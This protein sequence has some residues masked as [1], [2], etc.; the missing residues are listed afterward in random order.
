MTGTI[1]RV[2]FFI[3]LSA[4]AASAWA[5]TV[6]VSYD[7]VLDAPEDLIS[8]DYVLETSID[9]ESGIMDVLF[10]QGHIVFN[11]P[12]LVITD[13]EAAPGGLEQEGN[14]A[15]RRL[16]ALNGGAEMLIYLRLRFSGVSEDDL[17]LESLECE[18]FRL[19]SDME[20]IASETIQYRRDD[21]MPVNGFEASRILM[22][23]LSGA[24]LF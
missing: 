13:P 4:L 11:A 14:L 5:K 18:V 6:M 12:G 9:V 24:E 8:S 1:R 10:D 21:A 20:Q 17:Q 23:R 19:R 3:L 15:R 22:N 16:L 2:A 7:L